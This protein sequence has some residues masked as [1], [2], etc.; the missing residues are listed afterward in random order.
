MTPP[1]FEKGNKKVMNAW[2]MYDWANSVYSLVITSAIFP[3]YYTAITQPKVDGV[4]TSKMVN[5]F[6]FDVLASSLYSYALSISF[7]IVAIF[8]P[9]LSSI[10]DYTG[11]KKLFMRFFCYLGSA[12]CVSLYFFVDKGDV[13]LAIISC[14][15]ASI[16][17]AGSL[18][19]YNAYLPIIAEPKDHDRLS[20][21]GFSLGY[22]GSVILLIFCLVLVQKPDL[23]GLPDAAF[24]SRVSFLLVGFWWFFFAHITFFHLPRNV[25]KKKPTGNYLWKGYQELGIVWK[26]LK[27]VK[28]LKLFLGGFFFYN[29]G[30]LTIMYM[31][32]IFGADELKLDSSFLI[33]TVLVIQLIAIVGAYGFSNLSA[34]IGNINTLTIAIF[35]W[36]GICISAY[37][38][39]NQWQFL[40]LAATVGLVMGGTQSLSRSTYSKLL[41][42]TKDHAAFFSFYDVC[43]KLGTTIGTL[44]YGY[45]TAI[46]GM[47]NVVFPLMLFF[48]VGYLFLQRINKQKVEA[49]V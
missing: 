44:V 43:E 27:K 6:G 48:F 37:F 29:M 34:K 7:L 42:E 20:A 49:A 2:A 23:F 13:E 33:I 31:A 10:A 45:V 4:I 28:S 35:I 17:F 11:S 26:E 30:V 18:V 38:V 5:F 39:A 22:I 1:T 9:L 16:G 41:P 21:K 47:R 40:G 36:I 46:S 3:I 14:T 8:S 12:A 24:A 32:A 25:F 19:F 15:L